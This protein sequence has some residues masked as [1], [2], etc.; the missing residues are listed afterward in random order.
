MAEMKIGKGMTEWQMF[1][2]F[3]KLSQKYWVV[4]DENGAYWDGLVREAGEFARK[5]G[6]DFAGR[7]ALALVD[8]RDSEYRKRRGDCD[9]QYGA[10]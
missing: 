3:W 10:D 4:E 9:V 6:T 1:T 8:S 5:Y 2:D 7:L